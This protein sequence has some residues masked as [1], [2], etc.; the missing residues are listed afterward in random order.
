MQ[1]YQIPM[2]PGPVS[3]TPVA[4]RSLTTDF[5]AGYCEEEFFE[6]YSATAS[7]LAALLGTKN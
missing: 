1:N 4:Y 5:G 6:I 3:V 2:V 7:K